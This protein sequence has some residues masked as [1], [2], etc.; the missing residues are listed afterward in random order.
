ME[1]CT[2]T[3]QRVHE[4]QETYG[5]LFREISQAMKAQVDRDLLSQ[6]LTFAQ[7]HALNYLARQ[8][9]RTAPL[10]QLQRHFAVAQATMASLVVRIEK[11]GLLE[12]F[13]DPDDR[14]V[15]MLRLTP[16]GL[17]CVERNH[18][19]MGESERNLTR[20]LTDAERQELRRLLLIVR[21]NARGER[22]AGESHPAGN[23]GKEG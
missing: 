17:A 19:A 14:R 20:G 21:D 7:L 2:D 13:P 10:K 4:G 5:L 23:S 6:D 8:E 12:S 16:E 9:G 3:L 11:K 22:P 15:K 18:Q 1:Q